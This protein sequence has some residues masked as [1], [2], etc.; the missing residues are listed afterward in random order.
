MPTTDKEYWVPNNNWTKEILGSAG[1]YTDESKL[2]TLNYLIN[3]DSTPNPAIG[4]DKGFVTTYQC[5]KY[6]N[7]EKTFTADPEAMGKTARF[8]CTAEADVCK[9]LRL[10]LDDLGTLTLTN[11][12]TNAVLWTSNEI[13][14]RKPTP[15][16]VAALA[17]HTAALGKYKRNY[18]EP[19]EFLDV[20]GNEWIGSPTGKYRL[21]MSV[22]G[23]QVVYNVFGC[24]NLMNLSTGSGSTGSTDLGSSDST[25]GATLLYLLPDSFTQYIG[26]LGYIDD[27]GQLKM[28]STYAQQ[29]VNTYETIGN[30]NIMG[31]DIGTASTKNSASACQ[32]QCNSTPQCAGFVYDLERKMCYLKSK[33]VYQLPRI[34]DSTAE[35]QLRNKGV[36]VDASCPTAVENKDSSFWA[37]AISANNLSTTEMNSTKKCGLALYT[38]NERAS[39]ASAQTPLKSNVTGDFSANVNSLYGKYTTLKNSLLSTKA[40]K[41]AVASDLT[42]TQNALGDWN[43]EKFN[44]LK[45]MGEDTD[46]NMMSQN[47]RHIMWSILAIVII[48]ATMKI[49]KS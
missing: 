25:E 12:Q 48:I 42:K 26:N 5:G 28:Y 21:M 6:T 17:E 43:Y 13:S 49:A 41:V 24:N 20:S 18:L 45:A 32:T 19:G 38:Q 34:I 2:S 40:D 16:S 3:V 15:D 46:I 22:D 14:N 7:T 30:Y 36:N 23:L 9:P 27:T 44:Q 4:C 35:F 33:E 31:A 11:T 47:Y 10:T 8:D 1:E 39:V 37:S 29:Y